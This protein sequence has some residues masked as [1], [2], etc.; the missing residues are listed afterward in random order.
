MPVGPCQLVLPGNVCEMSITRLTW[1]SGVTVSTSWW[2][3]STAYRRPSAL[4]RLYQVPS[5]SKSARSGLAAGCD[6]KKA[7]RS[8]TWVTRW[9]SGSTRR[10]ALTVPAR[11]CEQPAPASTAYSRRPMKATSATP[12]TKLPTAALVVLDGNPSTTVARLPVCTSIREI[13]AVIPPAY[14]PAPGTCGHCPIVDAVPPTPPSATYGLPSGPNVRPRGFSSPE[15]STVTLGAGRASARAPP[16]T[17]TPVARAAAATTAVNT[18]AGFMVSPVLGFGC[19]IWPYGR[20]QPARSHWR[21][22]YTECGD[23]LARGFLTCWPYVVVR[24]NRLPGSNSRSRR[25]RRS[26]RVPT[27]GP[28]RGRCYPGIISSGTLWS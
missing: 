21:V 23:R 20:L 1:P 16:A 4:T 6:I 24:P 22:R 28:A 25:P 26:C 10:T 7:L 5:G 2:L 3:G 19:D 13:R 14:G 18:M 12:L 9:C 27:G 8:A 11:P 17:E 15:V